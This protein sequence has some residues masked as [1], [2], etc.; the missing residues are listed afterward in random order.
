M[1][2]L[3][4]KMASVA[5]RLWAPVLIL[6]VVLASG[7]YVQVTAEQPEARTALGAALMAGPAI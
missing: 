7:L 6:L 3:K 1:N 4:R 2:A 5:G